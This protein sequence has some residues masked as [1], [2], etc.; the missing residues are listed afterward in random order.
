[1]NKVYGWMDEGDNGPTPTYMYD[2]KAYLLPHTRTMANNKQHVMIYTLY[3]APPLMKSLPD[4]MFTRIPSKALPTLAKSRF[5]CE[6]GWHMDNVAFSL[7]D[8]WERENRMEEGDGNIRL[9]H[10]K[11]F[12]LWEFVFPSQS[13][14]FHYRHSHHSLRTRFSL[15]VLALSLS[16]LLGHERCLLP[17]LF[18]ALR[19]DT[20]ALCTRSRTHWPHCSSVARSKD[21][22][23]LRSLRNGRGFVAAAEKE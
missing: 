11:R 1:M 10:L 23:G 2:N 13:L 14:S 21:T 20:Q 6:N 4:K 19:W 7:V 8:Y 17:F 15:T 9:M 5:L 18:C 22:L 3:Y 16:L 12:L